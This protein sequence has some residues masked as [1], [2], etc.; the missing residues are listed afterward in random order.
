MKTSLHNSVWISAPGNE[1]PALAKAFS[2]SDGQPLSATLRIAAPG[3]YEA[4]LDGSR[5]GDAVLDPAPT[6]YTKRVYF[7]EWAGWDVE[8][9]A[10]APDAEHPDK[11]HRVDDTPRKRALLDGFSVKSIQ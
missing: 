2:V 10:D 1:A 3:F 9:E 7:R 8:K 6:D 4:W 5:V 11:Y